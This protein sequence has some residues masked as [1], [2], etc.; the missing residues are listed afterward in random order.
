MATWHWDGKIVGIPSFE[1]YSIAERPLRDNLMR[2]LSREMEKALTELALEVEGHMDVD[3]DLETAK[4]L[5]EKY[6]PFMYIG[7]W[8][9]AGEERC[10]FCPRKT[11]AVGLEYWQCTKTQNVL[12]VCDKCGAREYLFDLTKDMDS[13]RAN[14]DLLVL[15]RGIIPPEGS[16]EEFVKAS[17]EAD[18]VLETLKTIESKAIVELSPHK[19]AG[20]VNLCETYFKAGK[21]TWWKL[22]PSICK[23]YHE[24]KWLSSKQLSV[25]RKYLVACAKED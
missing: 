8:F 9:N 25:L 3:F 11:P 19:L 1:D 7:K 10:D 14:E 24:K 16:V 21:A 5:K 17:K 18:E 23:Q 2:E 4:F 22:I 13:A 12:R 20:L 6:G 15:D